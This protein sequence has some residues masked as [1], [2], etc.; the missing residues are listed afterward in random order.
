MR[1]L[2]DDRSTAVGYGPICADHYGLPW[3]EAAAPAAEATAAAEAATERQE[4]RDERRRLADLNAGE[5]DLGTARGTA[6]S[7]ARRANREFAARAYAPS[8]V[9][10]PTR[11][12]G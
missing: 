4:L 11:I 5:R 8:H 9:T 10:Y 7:R 6:Q 1:A 12:D 2:S 3:G